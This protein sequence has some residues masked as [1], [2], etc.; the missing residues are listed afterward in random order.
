MQNKQTNVLNNELLFDKN[1]I[2]KEK[3][4]SWQMMYLV[5][6]QTEMGHEITPYCS[7]KDTMTL[8]NHKYSFKH[9]II[10]FNIQHTI[11][12]YEYLLGH[13]PYAFSFF[14]NVSFINIDCG[15][16]TCPL[17]KCYHAVL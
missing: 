4:E 17:T 14:P 11:Q 1:E 16:G 8:S 13:L 9:A 6:P 2:W 15:I 10:I 12:H 7:H 5:I 3:Q